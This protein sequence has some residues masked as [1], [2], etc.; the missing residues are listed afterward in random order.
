MIVY[1]CNPLNMD[2]VHTKR[3]VDGF[4]VCEFK[5][6]FMKKDPT[7]LYFGVF[8]TIIIPIILL[9]FSPSMPDVMI[10]IGSIAALD[11]LCFLAHKTLN[12]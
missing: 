6:I 2:T 5:E 11:G 8:I 7:F 4:F 9:L 3:C 12:K 1:N 10:A